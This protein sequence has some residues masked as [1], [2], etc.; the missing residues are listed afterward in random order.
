LSGFLLDTNITS[1]LIRARPDPNVERWVYAQ[2][3][4]SLYLSVVSIGELLGEIEYLTF[5]DCP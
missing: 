2:N 3:E 4:Q 5:L 1:E